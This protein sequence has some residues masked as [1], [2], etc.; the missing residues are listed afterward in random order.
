MKVNIRNINKATRLIEEAGLSLQNA[1]EAEGEKRRELL[2]LALIKYVH[3]L[4]L[5]AGMPSMAKLVKQQ[6]RTVEELLDAEI[7]RML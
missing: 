7:E 3:A 4:P 5:F 6:I 1:L 2:E